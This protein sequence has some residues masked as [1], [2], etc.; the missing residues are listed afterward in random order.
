[1]VRFC[2]GKDN[3]GFF[4]TPVPPLREIER[5]CAF[6]ELRGAFSVVKPGAFDIMQGF[7]ENRER[8]REYMKVT[9]NSRSALMALLPVCAGWYNDHE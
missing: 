1:M 7:L 5:V 3:T 2:S 9:K 4:G 6:P 8:I